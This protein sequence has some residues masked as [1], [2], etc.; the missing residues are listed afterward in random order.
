MRSLI[1]EKVT[2]EVVLK[3]Q[4]DL[5]AARPLIQSV[6]S[7]IVGSRA[8]RLFRAAARDAHRAV[9]ERD[10]DTVAMTVSDVGTV[11]AAATEALRPKL[12]EKLEPTDRVELIQRD[13][14]QAG[15]DA[16]RLADTIRVL[17]FVF[18]ALALLLV[19]GALALASDK[20]SAVVELGVGVAVAGVVLVVAYGIA[21]SIAVEHVEG[22]EARAAAGA[23]WDAFL[24]D[25]RT[26]AWILAGWGP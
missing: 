25:L 6:A 12:A 13:L 2:D 16:A 4:R 21:R 1:A 18:L 15:G 23:V 10:R 14:G 5:I 26:A 11:L 24:Q 22:P 20:R 8:L 19:A 9:F 17:P 3:H 7:G